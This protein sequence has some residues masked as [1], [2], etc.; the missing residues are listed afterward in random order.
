MTMDPQSHLDFL[1]RAFFQLVCHIL[2]QTP[3]SYGAQ[4]DASTFL[5]TFSLHPDDDQTLRPTPWQYAPSGDIHG[6]NAAEP[7]ACLHHQTRLIF[8]NV[9]WP[10]MSQAIPSAPGYYPHADPSTGRPRELH[11][12]MAYHELNMCSVVPEKRPA[13]GSGGDGRK[14]RVKRK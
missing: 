7:D 12:I 14:K 1:V 9:Y 5:N 13:D 11:I 4:I 3:T 8:T 2:R 6:R 10:L